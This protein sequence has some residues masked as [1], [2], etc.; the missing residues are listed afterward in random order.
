M[1][2]FTYPHFPTNE[3]YLTTQTQNKYIS[4][5]ISRELLPENAHRMA[6]VISLNASNHPHTPIQ[7]WQLYSV[8]GGE[9][10]IDIVSHFYDRVYDDDAWF[11]SVFKRI[12]G[13]HHHIRTQSAMWIDAMGGGK[14]YHG[15]EYRLSFH[16]THNAFE[17][18]TSKGAERWISLMVQTLDDPAIDL[19]DDTRVRP[20]INTFLDFFM[21]K[22]A[23]DFQFSTDSVFGDTNP[24]LKRFNLLRMSSDEVESLSD[25]DLKEALQ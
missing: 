18:M 16:H 21:R 17:L 10:I 15:G 7:F 3:G 2:K 8:L 25:L 20:S 22:Y 14:A 6:H 5:A 1:N 4:D 9:R 11:A 19:T 23:E 13:K 12:S 24:P